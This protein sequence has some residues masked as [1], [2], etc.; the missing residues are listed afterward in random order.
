MYNHKRL[1]YIQLV[2]DTRKADENRFL[3]FLEL[4]EQQR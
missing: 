3:R 4:R 1:H 2:N